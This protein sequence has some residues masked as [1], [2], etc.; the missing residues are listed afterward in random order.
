MKK[1]LPSSKTISKSHIFY[2]IKRPFKR[3]IF[4]KKFPNS[5]YL[6][7]NYYS[8]KNIPKKHHKT[9]ATILNLIRKQN[10]YEKK[11][12]EKSILITRQES[13]IN[14]PLIPFLLVYYMKRVEYLIFWTW[15]LW[16]DDNWMFLEKNEKRGTYN[17]KDCHYMFLNFTKLHL[18]SRA[19]AETLENKIIKHLTGETWLLLFPLLTCSQ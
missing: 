15:Q 5:I 12:Q 3:L 8:Y 9:L 19:V 6:K 17:I 10:L 14:F 4:K 7:F 13:E 18:R 2:L 11:G 1:S 16:F